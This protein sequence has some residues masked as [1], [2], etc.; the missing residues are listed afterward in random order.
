MKLQVLVDLEA[1]KKELEKM[2][3]VQN[4]KKKGAV[5]LLDFTTV[6]TAF[7]YQDIKSYDKIY[8][9]KVLRE[10]GEN[11]VKPR[12]NEVMKGYSKI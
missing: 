7:D 9:D 8:R 12:K 2:K 10:I 11:L 5:R 3:M 6:C 1:L 4:R